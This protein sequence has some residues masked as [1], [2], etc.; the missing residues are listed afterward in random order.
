MKRFSFLNKLEFLFAL[1]AFFTIGPYLL[2]ETYSAYRIFDVIKMLLEIYIVLRT[3]LSINKKISKSSFICAVNFLVV[4]IYYVVDAYGGTIQIGLGTIMKAIII[5]LFILLSTEQKAHVFLYF[6]KIF[7]V[8][9][10]PAI[11]FSV[12]CILDIN[13]SGDFIE[14]TQEIK[15]LYNQHYLH[16]PGCVF[17]E[18]IYYSPRFKQLCG[19]FDEPGMVGTLCSLILIANSFSLKKDTF[20]IPILVAGVLS[21]SF[22]FYLILAIYAVIKVITTKRVTKRASIV[23]ACIVVIIFL[24]RNNPILDKFVFSRFS[25]VNLV[26]NNRTSVE[27]DYLFESFFKEGNHL[28]FGYGNNNPIFDTVDVSSYKLIIYNMGILGFLI[29]VGWFLNWGIKYASTNKNAMV[30]LICFMASI[31]QRPFVL[32]LY[33]IVILFGGASYCLINRKRNF[34]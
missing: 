14:T 21:M 30:L 5:I 24:F 2:W 18:N 20:L 23:V 6:S 11:F 26:N 9:L 27:F 32:Y 25:L 10:I 8:S 3:L 19:M 28:L 29:Y 31:Y 12:L 33:Y 7:A 4:Y 22:A 15:S 34:N 17:R 1:D 13:P 16:F